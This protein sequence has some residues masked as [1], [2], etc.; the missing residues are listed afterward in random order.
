MKC[1]AS[2][3]ALA[4]FFANAAA[5][6]SIG[7]ILPTSLIDNSG[8]RLLLVN[9][10]CSE[11]IAAS[12]EVSLGGERVFSGG[13]VRLKKG[14]NSLRAMLPHSG[15]VNGAV[16]TLKDSSGAVLTA[17]TFSAPAAREWTLYTIS[18][19]HTDMGLHEPY[20]AQARLSADCLSKG[21]E[22]VRKKCENNP[23]ES[24]YRYVAEG[25][26]V[27]DCFADFVGER[28]ALDYAR[29]YV[30][31][32]VVGVGASWAGN[33]MHLYSAEE[34]CRSAYSK[35]ELEKKWGIKTDTMLM[36]DNPGLPWQMVA[37]Y[38]EAGIRNI[39]WSPNQWGPNRSTVNKARWY[40][41][42]NPDA[43]GGG[44][45]VDV[46]WHSELP[47][48]FNWIGADGKSR[49]LVWAN[50][51]YT[52]GIFY[53]TWRE[54]GKKFSPEE[55]D[56]RIAR[57]L[58]LMEGKV[59]YD[60]WLFTSYTDNEFPNSRNADFAREWNSRWKYPRIRTLAD[61]SEPFEEVR[62]RFG[63]KIPELSGDITNAWA[64]MACGTPML[65]SRKINADR[66]LAVAEKCAALAS[67]LDTRYRYPRGELSLAWNS[68][69]W[70]DE[71]SYGFSGYQG[72][73]VFETWIQHRDWIE[74]AE[75]SAGEILESAMSS[76][77]R[78]AS[79]DSDGLL[80]FNPSLFP[81][82][83]I[84]EAA[85][86]GG[87]T[88]R[89]LTPE[90][91]SFGYAVVPKPAAGTARSASESAEPP[92]VE[93]EFY[94]LA[95]SPDGSLKSIF[96]KEQNREIL[97]A[98]ARFG[99]NC[100]VFTDDNHKTLHAP[101]NAAFRVVSEPVGTSVEVSSEE[102][103][104]G[105]QIVQRIFLPNAEKRI[106]F[107]NRARNMRAL[108]NDDRHKRF[109][110]FS[111]PF[112]AE[113]EF[114]FFASCGGC[115]AEP[116]RDVTGHGTDAY[117]FVRDWCAMESGGGGV[118][119]VQLDTCPVEFGKIH[120]DKTVFGEKF[121]SAGVYSYVVND[122]L[123]MHVSS[124]SQLE[125]RARYA[126]KSYRGDYRSAQI[127][128]FAERAA[129]PMPVAE[130]RKGERSLPQSGSYIECADSN[131]ELLAL[132]RS[133][134]IG[135]GFL[136]RF[137]ET[138]GAPATSAKIKISP[139][140]GDRLSAVNVIETGQMEGRGAFD[141]GKFGYSSVNISRGFAKAAPEPP[142]NLSASARDNRVSLSWES[143]VEKFAVFRGEFDGFEA[144]EYH[145]IAE[146]LKPEFED[147]GLSPKSKYFYR[148]RAL[149]A[150]GSA[151]R[152]SETF[153]AET[154]AGNSP[155]AKAA[156]GGRRFMIYAPRGSR[157]EKD[158]QLYLL[159]SA[160]AESDLSHYEIYRS[161]RSGFVPDEKTFVS[162]VKPDPQFCIGRYED[163]GLDNFTTYYYRVR[164]VDMD[165]N[166]GEFSDEFSATTRDK[167][168][169]AK[170]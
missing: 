65:L 140:F 108:F 59:P 129:N 56:E 31:K 23:D 87:K 45:R 126:L 8:G 34:L 131:I 76:I 168:F 102:P 134:N 158:G 44:S 99:A 62:K 32:K 122:G 72:R 60:I 42:C 154:A 153:V 71:H 132:K 74:F 161:K 21:V 13:S 109:G 43:G 142:K 79:S 121:A 147:V 57:K 133:E 33:H 83:E 167:V 118:A 107:D 136:A 2:I 151:S 30:D 36:T 46:S 137:H 58:A 115:I 110:Y 148:V 169:S 4:L 120:S 97:D 49:I 112:A 86:E 135:G 50:T 111:F 163:G 104:S 63:G 40:D 11:D 5:E 41:D 101:R 19:T 29:R 70:N 67:A 81:R 127:A 17:K 164:A 82:S 92:I 96:D 51:T 113:G 155:P 106:D 68:L 138:D 6:V 80:V 170:K 61:I 141:F 39:I 3:I 128:R 66:K 139:V 95:F 25:L 152:A 69:I 124:G 159:W 116:K 91:P 160:N 54:R 156:E 27:W 15:A 144:D 38:A 55:I 105:A 24:K 89:F 90:I 98:R 16:F 85:V 37:P 9:A 150:D 52:M 143:D 149:G 28:A 78:L 47:M 157:G 64:T 117:M 26:W 10:E 146:C 84:V 119:L 12:A 123:Q 35:R 145:F 103:R 18:S 166:K 100:F 162:D 1:T 75:K 114:K 14:G 130:I 94:R 77:A 93:N 48:L 125:L 88:A 73:R 53:K 7:E 22:S 20:Y 165:G